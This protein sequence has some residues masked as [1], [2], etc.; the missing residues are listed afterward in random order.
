MKAS[1]WDW[2][3]SAL[4]LVLI[5]IALNELRDPPQERLLLRSGRARI[6]ILL[7]TAAVLSGWLD[8]LLAR[9]RGDANLIFLFAGAVLTIAAIAIFPWR[10]RKAAQR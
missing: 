1:A 9:S 2:L 10:A 5:I 4:W 7:Y 6:S 3:T 8:L